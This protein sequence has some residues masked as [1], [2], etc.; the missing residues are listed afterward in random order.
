[1]S[2]TTWLYR[3]IDNAPL[4]L[5]RIFLGFLLAVE[6]FGAIATG[7]VKENLAGPEFTFSYIGLEWLQPLPGIG[8]YLYFAAMGCCGLLVMVGWRYRWSLGAF[9]LL[10]AGAYLM[11]KT[12]YNNHYYLLLLVC[13]IMLFLPADRAVSLDARRDPALRSDRMPWWC[14]GVMVFQVAIV[15]FFAAIAKLYP[16]WMDGT[17]VGI[18][19]SHASREM[20]LPL[21]RNHDFHLFIAWTG[22]FFDFFIV[23]LFLWKKTR[24][25]ALASSV[26]FHI[27]NAIFL[28]IGIFPFFALSFAVFFY[29]PERIR[30]VFFRKRKVL[31]SEPR[32]AEGRSVLLWFF[33]P[34]FLLQLA[35]PVRHWFIEGDVLWT[36]EG[37]RLSWRMMLR[38]R[39][40]FVRF[41]VVDNATGRP[42]AY[43]YHD[44]L[45]PKQRGFIGSKPDGIWQMAQHI[46][47]QF[48]EKGRD[49]SVYAD[50]KVSI[51]GGPYFDLIDPKTDLATAEWS[52]VRHN[53]WILPYG[54][55]R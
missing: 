2:R 13:V 50:A 8:M 18:A 53:R 38:Q 39:D 43:S 17:F 15:Y 7:W 26:A 28:Q 36:E 49:V 25:L 1:M 52:H 37:H 40:G 41:R 44:E 35:L 22:F 48:A 55:K 10:W 6:T 19:L 4:I 14:S 23:P 11:Q 32:P 5:F 16:G 30:A 12:A 33:L 20:G 34:Y 21:L 42:V 54:Q 31:D 29:P 45:T 3:P 9:T 24:T 27:F 47:R 51:N 46:H